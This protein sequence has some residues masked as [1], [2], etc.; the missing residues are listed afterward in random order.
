MCDLRER[1][2]EVMEKEKER[3]HGKS[4]VPGLRSR[5]NG[6]AIPGME[7]ERGRTSEGLG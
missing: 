3:S 2:K 5:V 4:L 6:G 7:K 1:E